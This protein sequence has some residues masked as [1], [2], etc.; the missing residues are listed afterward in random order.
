[1]IHKL[2][3]ISTLIIITISVTACSA[4]KANIPNPASV[5]C[6]ENGGTVD[7][8]TNED[9]SQVG[10]C[11]FEDGSECEEWAY[12][13]NECKPGDS[14][15]KEIGMPNP[16]SV[17]CEENKGKL[18]IRTDELGGQVGFCLFED[19]SECEEWAFYRGECK[20]GDSLGQGIGM[21]NPASV[22]CQEKGGK[23]E[24]I[25]DAYG[26]QV[27]M[28]NFADGS[29][30]EEWAYHRGDCI[31]GGFYLLEEQADDGCDLYTSEIFSYSLHIPKESKVTSVGDPSQTISI[32]GPI[33]NDDHWPMIY[34]NHPSIEIYAN[35]TEDTNLE[36]WLT[37]NY[38]LGEERKEDT[39]IAG[40]TA[41]HLRHS[42]SPQSYASDTFF[43]IHNNQLFSIVILHTADKE[44]WDLYN[45]FLENI[46][47][48]E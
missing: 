45:H 5:F 42:R 11:L 48:K 25:T 22:N 30:C 8:R 27:G 2:I 3:T 33:F 34:V 23:L 10:Y 40:E 39:E 32:I 31:E 18:E 1:M 4:E 47:F 46:S 12:Y 14:I 19:G 37:E 20:H 21:P 44:D 38:L 9:G 15:E 29:A 6:E 28:C 24:I 13:R 43:F 36:E 17:F 16:A 26:N 35:I 41:I 7:I